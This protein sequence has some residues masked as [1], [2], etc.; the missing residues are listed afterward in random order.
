MAKIVIG[1]KAKGSERVEAVVNSINGIG[2]YEVP[3]QT[4]KHR[5]ESGMHLYNGYLTGDVPHRI[6]IYV[7][8]TIY[9]NQTAQILAYESATSSSEIPTEPEKLVALERVPL[10]SMPKWINGAGI[11]LL[12]KR[13]EIY[14][15]RAAN[16][17]EKK[18]VEG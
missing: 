3:G 16:A 5:G 1:K 14:V 6:R 2:N 13:D 8:T 9:D 12:N 10:M 11:L 17:L 15:N 18:L 7:P 4:L